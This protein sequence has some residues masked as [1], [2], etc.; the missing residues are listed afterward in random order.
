MVTLAIHLAAILALHCCGGILSDAT[1]ILLLAIPFSQ[2]SLVAIWAATVVKNPAARCVIP[3][4]GISVIWM[5]IRRIMPWGVGEAASVGW[6]V[7]LCTQAATVIAAVLC[8]KIN[9][10]KRL[11]P[12]ID[13]Q[14]DDPVESL[15][16]Q[17]VF[18][19]GTLLVVTTASAVV[20]SFVRIGQ[21]YWQW[22]PEM[23][24]WELMGAMPI[25]GMASGLL[26]AVWLWALVSLSGKLGF[27]MVASAVVCC[28]LVACVHFG[29]LWATGSFVLS[30]PDV[31]Y[32]F[33]A[34]S[35]II[36]VSL[37]L[38]KPSFQAFA[39]NKTA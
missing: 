19:I 30:L 28:C 17:R 13:L 34:Q 21:R 38:S 37:A 12:P 5:L 32:N 22:T 39:A 36:C 25:I 23:L 3:M 24:Q 26:A 16:E 20:V 1:M 11:Y 8:Y 18:G 15:A 27:R 2:L 31:T 7:A 10:S 35:A 6:A 14:N 33:A 4:F 29:T 9:C